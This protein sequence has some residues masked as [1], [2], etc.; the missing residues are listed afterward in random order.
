MVKGNCSSFEPAIIDTDG[1]L[2]WVGTAGLS[3]GNVIL[4]DNAVY[5]GHGPLLSRIDLDGPFTL[6]GDYSSLGIVTF[7]HNIDRG[8][9]GIILDATTTT[10]VASTLMEVDVSGTVLKRWDMAAIISAAMRAGGDDPP[11]CLPSAE[12]L[13]HIN[14]SAFNGRTTP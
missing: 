4:F 2:R 6:L 13:F 9:V 14:G 1:A 10:S 8:K 11:L 5:L 7:H 3:A 12:R